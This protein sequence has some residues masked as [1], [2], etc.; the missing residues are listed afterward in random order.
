[1]IE[2]LSESLVETPVGE[3]RIVANDQKLLGIFWPADKRHYVWDRGLQTT[4]QTH[5]KTPV[6][7]ETSAQLKAYFANQLTN[8]DLPIELKGTD[9]QSRVWR[10][11]RKCKPGKTWS[12]L[13]LA[14]RLEE[15]KAVRA[16]AAAV[17][18]NPISI[19]LPC[20]RI[21]GSNG[22]LTGFAGGL[23]AK[24][25]LLEFEGALKS[26]HVS[27]SKAKARTRH[28]TSAK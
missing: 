21:I 8:F 4:A 6:L 13:E 5:A 27:E 23:N 12:Y 1:M 24:K 9:F 18:R 10:E 2:S 17:G 16:V 19:V 26:Q 25:W 15:P 11:L 7:R 3:L 28:S 22:S 14:E 20:H